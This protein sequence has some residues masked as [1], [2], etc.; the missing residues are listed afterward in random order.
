[1]KQSNHHFSFSIAVNNTTEKI[2]QTLIDVP[3]WQVWD[4]ELKQAQL[5]G[6]F[7]LNAQGT[8]IPKTGPK[9]NFHISEYTEYQSYTF[10]IK[11][12]L[13]WL[14]IKR[15]ISTANGINYFT[16]D[17]AFTG[18]LKYVFG[19]ILGRQFKKVL[20]EVMNNFKKIVESRQ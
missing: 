13:G 20:P 18:F 14:V 2:W 7:R 11:M 4:T 5:E 8:L 12:P 6:E 17:I 1:M 10:K 9:L 19:F 15:T 3:T 16:D